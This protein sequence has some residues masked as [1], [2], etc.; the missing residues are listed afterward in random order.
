MTDIDTGSTPAA[1]AF[2]VVDDE[3]DFARAAAEVDR[4]TRPLPILHGPHSAGGLLDYP[5]ATEHN[6][7]NW[8]GEVWCCDDTLIA[9]AR[10][11]ARATG[12]PLCRGAVDD[13]VR[14][15]R[16]G[17]VTVVARPSAATPERLAAVPHDAQ[18]GWLITR[19]LAATTQIIARTVLHGPAV[20]ADMADLAFDTITEHDPA[21]GWLTADQLSP[22]GLRAGIGRGVAVLAGRGHARGC[23]MHLTGGGICGR[24]EERPLLAVQPAMS[25]DWVEH[26]TACQQGP[27]CHRDD[28]AVGDHLRS[29]DI[30]AAFAVLDSC[31]TAVA[32]GAR[33]RTDVSI[34]LSM[35]EGN[36]LAVCCA[37]GARNGAG[38]VAQLFR[39]LVR[40]GAA[41]G[42][43]VAEMNGSIAADRSARGRLALFGDAGLVPMASDEGPGAVRTP[44]D[45]RGGVEVPTSDSA[46]L[47][48][49]HGLLAVAA[50]GPMVVP[51]ASDPS[52]WVLTGVCGRSGGRIGQAP[53]W[54]DDRWTERVRP[55]LD[56]LRA[57]GS[58]GLGIGATDIDAAHRVAVRAVRARAEAEELGAAEDAAASFAQAERKLAELQFQ[59][60]DKEIRWTAKTYYSL[61]DSW[62]EPLR[63]VGGEVLCECPQCGGMCA[64]R[65]HVRSAGGT[66]PKLRSEVCVR[67]GEVVAGVAEFPAEVV[68]TSPPEARL[69]DP[70][71]VRLTIQ[72]PDDHPLD[73][74]VGAAFVHEARFHCEL[75]DSRSITLRPGERTTTTFV[76]SSN[77]ARTIPDA[78]YFKV[79]LAADGAVRCLTRTVVFRA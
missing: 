45:E 61:L 74:A 76:G 49:G 5:I 13:A 46:V 59:L 55:W 11:L 48:P 20:T 65:Q 71:T 72:G 78:H 64:V 68:V 26:P 14:A 38:H 69:G 3:D 41:L 43:A 2:V 23:L 31:R 52:S 79:L 19:S 73:V 15:A 7:R 47:V 8:R 12:R 39:A 36:A 70:I 32:G 58:L 1:Q 29:A 66:G 6:P 10:V 16:S 33:V 63:L 24:Q 18:V 25:S 40:G 37:V 75:L 54:L 44:L 51:R 62:P 42:E 77:P 67:C 50:G 27:R 21:P 22:T 17:P 34:P 35:I 56:R 57:L 53:Q 28:V 4:M 9:A 60:V 30:R